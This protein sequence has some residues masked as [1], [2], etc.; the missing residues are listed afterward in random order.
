MLEAVELLE[1]DGFS[2][3]ITVA[4][5]FTLTSSAFAHGE[6]IP[7]RHT[8]DGADHPPPL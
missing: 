3:R 5:S 6:A 8:C 7:R 2:G 4:G 1:A